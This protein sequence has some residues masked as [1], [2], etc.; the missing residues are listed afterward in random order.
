MV[1]SKSSDQ[2]VTLCQSCSPQFPQGNGIRARR[3]LC[4]FLV[5]GVTGEEPWN[6]EIRL[7]IG[8]LV[9][10][11]NLGMV[12]KWGERSKCVQRGRRRG[13]CIQSPV[14]RPRRDITRSR[15]L[16]F[17]PRLVAIQPR[18]LLRRPH[19]YRNEKHPCR[20]VFQYSWKFS[21]RKIISIFT[22]ICVS[23]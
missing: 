20:I 12:V 7:F 14:T 21:G 3:Y 22:W 15:G 2:S 16:Y 11:S 8:L 23:F 4:M 5:S 10:L 1:R 9:C 18:P 6:E 13:L 19:L 17:L